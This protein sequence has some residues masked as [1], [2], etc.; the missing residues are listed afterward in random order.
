MLSGTK[1]SR[2]P[3][4][5]P[6]SPQPRLLSGPT[7]RFSIGTTLYGTLKG[8]PRYGETVNSTSNVIPTTETA[9]F[10]AFSAIAVC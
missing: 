10:A 2:T 8:C 9:S 6:V 4:A 7:A 3:L 5:P 1:Y